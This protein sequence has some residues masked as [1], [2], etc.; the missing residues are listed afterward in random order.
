[1]WYERQFLI[2]SIIRLLHF[3]LHTFLNFRLF[4]TQIP[5]NMR[6]KVYHYVSLSLR[7]LR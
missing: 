2:L 3:A 7:N 6:T 1:M 4:S 5:T